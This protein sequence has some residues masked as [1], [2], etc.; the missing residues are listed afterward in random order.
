MCLSSFACSSIMPWKIPLFTCSSDF[1]C[2]LLLVC[3]QLP[4]WRCLSQSAATTLIG[5]V[6]NLQV[7]LCLRACIDMRVCA[8]G[9]SDRSNADD[10]QRWHTM[11]LLFVSRATAMCQGL[12]CQP[13]KKVPLITRFARNICAWLRVSYECTIDFSPCRA[14][15]IKIRPGH[16]SSHSSQCQTQAPTSPTPALSTAVFLSWTIR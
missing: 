16:K 12:A 3:C 6:S 15:C 5:M 8:C 11:C 1:S 9:N 2:R 7:L 10:A 4:I 14:E 13:W